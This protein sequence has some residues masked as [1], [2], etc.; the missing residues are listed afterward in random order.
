MSMGRREAYE[1]FRHDYEHNDTIESNKRTLKRLCVEA[2]QLGEQLA[3]SRNKISTFTILYLSINNYTV[4]HKNG[5]LVMCC[6]VAEFDIQFSQ[7]SAAT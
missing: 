4:S 5:T 2:K 3:E 1:L 7:G 6:K